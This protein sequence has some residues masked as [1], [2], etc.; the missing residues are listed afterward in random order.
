MVTG[1]IWLAIGSVVVLMLSLA[2]LAGPKGISG[3]GLGLEEAH[4]FATSA[5]GSQP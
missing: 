4:P 2:C 3:E 5:Q 1:L